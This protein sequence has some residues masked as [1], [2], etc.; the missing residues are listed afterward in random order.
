MVVR[1][2]NS[3]HCLWF[4]VTWGQSEIWTKKTHRFF[5]WCVLRH[6]TSFF[7]IYVRWGSKS[8]LQS[9]EIKYL[10]W[11]KVRWERDIV[12][13]CLEKLTYRSYGDL[14]KLIVLRSHF[15]LRFIF[16]QGLIL[17]RVPFFALGLI[18][19]RVRF[20]HRVSFLPKVLF[21]PRVPFFLPFFFSL[22]SLFI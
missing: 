6:S 10:Y 7:L 19:P 22:S 21:F 17:S 11:E 3:R 20:L 9:W 1:P 5:P 12:F 14:R 8:R 18:L 13:L 15:G 2:S 4:L 16:V